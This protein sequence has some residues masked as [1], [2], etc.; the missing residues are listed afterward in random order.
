MS[1]LVQSAKSSNR[2]MDPRSTIAAISLLN[3]KQ[4]MY[5][6]KRYQMTGRE[7][8]IAKRIC[9]GLSC[10]DIAQELDIKS[11]TVKTHVRN[12]YR[13]TWVHTKIG[14]LLKFVTDSRELFSDARHA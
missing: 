2:N 10:E 14:M 9:E 1:Q 13:K 11:G 4:W 5:L 12:I 6:Q 3:E 7:V 8:Q